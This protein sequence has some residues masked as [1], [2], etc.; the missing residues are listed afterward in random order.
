MRALLASPLAFLIG[1]SLG[2]LGGGGSIL[3]VPV[4]VFAAGQEPAAATSTSLLLVAVT[5]A[6]A[7]VPHARAH[8]VRARDGI[9]FALTGIPATLLGGRLAHDLD[10]DV[11]L[12]GF[13][14]VMVAAGVTMLR[15]HAGPS[16]HPPRRA[17]PR[18]L[19]VAVVGSGVGLLTGTF[20]VGGGFVVVPALV[21][22]LGLPMADAV[23]TSLLVIVL[24]SLVALTTRLHADS[25]DWRVV[26]PFLT[27]AM[28]GVAVGTHLTRH[29][30]D[31]RLRRAF[32]WLL[33][34]V[35]G[36]TA[37]RAGVGLID[38]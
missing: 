12:L 33:L 26:V 9:V 30:P 29:T 36:F 18:P 5:A 17:L 27:A 38:A 10:P 23:G 22:V 7:L 11:L 2:A 6:V 31:A 34:A 15:S 14:P 1:W 13:A 4:L 3:A 25:I 20:G 28:L 35:A 37:V 19:L 24:N 21:L 32:A 16:T 8:H